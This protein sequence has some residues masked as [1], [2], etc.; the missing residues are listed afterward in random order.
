MRFQIG[1]DLGLALAKGVA[2][3]LVTVF[4][5]MPVFVLATYKWIDKTHHRP[6]LPSFERFGKVVCKMMI[7]FVCIFVLIIVPSYLASNSNSFYYGA[8]HIFGEET[9]LG[10]DTEKIENTF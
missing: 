2:I 4:V 6:F 3:S 8:S 5:F 9:Q 1:P 7:P 10:A